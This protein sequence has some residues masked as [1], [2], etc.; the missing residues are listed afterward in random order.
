MLARSLQL[1]VLGKVQDG[2]Q[3]GDGPCNRESGFYERKQNGQQRL[4]SQC[5]DRPL[6][7]RMSDAAVFPNKRPPWRER[8]PDVVVGYYQEVQERYHKD[9]VDCDHDRFVPP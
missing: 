4:A 1:L 5:V 7:W 9:F 8:M 3:H 2:G 6:Y